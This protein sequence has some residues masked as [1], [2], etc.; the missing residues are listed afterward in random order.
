MLSAISCRSVIPGPLNFNYHAGPFFHDVIVQR[1]VFGLQ[2]LFEALWRD[3][4]IIGIV[5]SMVPP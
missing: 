4:L 1:L 5:F 3:I 2:V